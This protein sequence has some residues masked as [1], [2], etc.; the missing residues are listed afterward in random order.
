[1]MS[2]WTALKKALQRRLL[3][4]ISS[5]LVAAAKSQTLVQL[6]PQIALVAAD[7]MSQLRRFG[8]ALCIIGVF[9]T[10]LA[11]L[12]YSEVTDPLHLSFT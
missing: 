6:G 4:W 11:G 1:M 12:R 7:Q 5:R 2:R 3:D 10:A 9:L 8:I